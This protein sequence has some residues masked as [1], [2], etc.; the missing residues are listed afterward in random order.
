[1]LNQ[2]EELKTEIGTIEKSL[3]RI[4]HISKT[5]SPTMS[6]FALNNQKKNVIKNVYQLLFV[7]SRLSNNKN[8]EWIEY[9][10]NIKKMMAD[11]V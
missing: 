5:I 10:E 6:N 1:M 4:I 11:L 7:I 9:I 3:E 8:K 2:I